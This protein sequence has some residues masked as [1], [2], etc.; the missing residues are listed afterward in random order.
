MSRTSIESICVFGSSARVS[1]DSL[2]D[3]DVLVVASEKCRRDNIVRHWRQ[4]GWSVAVY[5]PS[6]L[7]KMIEAQS[8]FVQHL[9]FEGIIV[10]DA[11]GWLADHLNNARPKQSYSLD[12]QRSVMLALP[13]ERLDE[14]AMIA[15]ELISADLAYVATRNFGVCYLADKDRLTFDYNQIIECLSKDFHLGSDEVALLRSLRSGKAAYRSK[16]QCSD[17]RGTVGELRGLLSKFF[18]ERPLGP[19]D[20][21]GPIRNLYTGYG[22]LRDFEAW[23]VSRIRRGNV[24]IDELHEYL[25]PLYRWICSPRSYSWDIRKI[26]AENLEGSR[27]AFE[28]RLIA[29]SKRR[30]FFFRHN[31]T[32]LVYESSKA[33]R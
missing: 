25:S 15:Q 20:Q 12:A 29:Q 16:R 10:E 27:L 17:V 5:S 14:G 23:V 8:L 24:Q 11:N 33:V 3:R 2:S 4:Q 6:R 19:I 13:L 28:S 32:S 31:L 22:T 18:V 30:Y 1:T 21:N 9:R 26:C 7:L